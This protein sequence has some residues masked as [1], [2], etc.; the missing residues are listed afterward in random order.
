MFYAPTFE[1]VSAKCALCRITCL[2]T[3]TKAKLNVFI[4]GLSMIVLVTFGQESSLCFLT[5]RT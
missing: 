2:Q 1:I 3:S 4:F 5:K